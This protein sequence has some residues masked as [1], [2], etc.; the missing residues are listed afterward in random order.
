MLYSRIAIQSSLTKLARAYS[1]QPEPDI[2]KHVASAFGIVLRQAIRFASDG[3]VGML[4]FS[5]YQVLKN[6]VG[7]HPTAVPFVDDQRGG[8]LNLKVGSRQ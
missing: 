7:R 1:S 2:S 5:L 8:A 6:A 4:E 3:L